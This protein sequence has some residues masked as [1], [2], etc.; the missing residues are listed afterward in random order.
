MAEGS[1][2][3]IGAELEESGKLKLAMAGDAALCEK[4][5]GA[6]EAILAAAGKGGKILVAGNGGSAGDSQHM[7]A[8]L[9]H[10]FRIDRR[11]PV[12]CI[13]LTTDSSIITAIGNDWGFG[14]IF[15]R[16]V[17]ALGR[18]G[19]VLIVFSTSGNSGNIV[20]A[21]EEAKRKKMFVIGFLGRGGGALGPLV[22]LALVVPHNDTA[23]IQEAHGCMLHIVCGQV[24]KGLG[25]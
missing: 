24:E 19:D 20:K 9:V 6:C 23:R 13:A 7:A 17:E 1:T 21:V 12:A 8:E 4:I 15:S 18:E 2:G 22:D 3:G 5:S 14:E 10:R 25:K 16:Q 11:E